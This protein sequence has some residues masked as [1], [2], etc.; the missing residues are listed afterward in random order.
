MHEQEQ[1]DQAIQ[2][3]QQAITCQPNF[4]EPYNNLGALLKEQRKFDQAIQ[5]YQQAIEIAP[6]NAEIH[7]N[8]GVIFQELGKLKEST[9]SYYQAIKINPQFAEAHKNLGILLLLKG[10]LNNGWKHYEWRNK[11]DDF[12]TGNRISPQRVWDGSNIEGK[13]ILVWAE[14]GIGDQIMFASIFGDLLKTK[15]NTIVE[16]EQ[17][18][19]PLFQRAFP[20]IDFVPKEHPIQPRLLDNIIN[21]Q[22]SMA[23][24]GR[25]FRPEERNF[26]SNK[27]FYLYPHPRKTSEIRHKYRKL[28]YGKMLVGIS[29]KSTGIDQKR[30]IIKSTSLRR[31]E[32]CFV[33]T[34]LFFC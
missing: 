11:C 24:L 8:L 5:V 28:A 19:I 18:L 30:T 2:I 12:P 15:A 23:G 26:L 4:I 14:Q 10:E 6:D 33:E 17:R 20:K 32:S 9:K 27:N 16:C 31:L 3:Y 13:S 1:F 21:Y 7:N 25:W 22:V 34:G 29:W